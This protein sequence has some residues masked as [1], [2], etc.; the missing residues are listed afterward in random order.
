MRHE[1]SGTRATFRVSAFL[2]LLAVSVF[3][4]E[5]GEE[6]TVA[7]TAL[8]ADPTFGNGVVVWDPA[9]GKHVVRGSLKP[10][11]DG[12]EPA[13]GAAQWHSRFTLAG[14][15]AEA[16]PDGRV[17][18]ADEAKGVVFSQEDGIAI[19]LDAIAEYQGKAPE[20]GDP[21]PHLL[22]SQPRLLH[23]PSLPELAAVR[24]RIRYRLLEAEPLKGPGWHDQRHTA[25]V[26]FFVTVQNLNRQS[27][28]YGDFLWFGVPLYDFRYRSPKAMAAPDVGTKKKAGTGKFMYVPAFD[29][30]S[31]QSPHDG[32]WVEIETDLLPM[33]K[34]AVADAWTR[35]YLKDSRDIAD[36]RL[37]GMN[38]GWEITGP[39]RAAAHI[40]R[41]SLGARLR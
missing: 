37:G 5:K 15:E 16:L 4:Q 25:Q 18:F 27:E 9:P 13:W 1:Q 35:G 17:R 6:K 32:H 24:F 23:H 31:K 21:W 26:V 28:G 11:P 2:L 36:Y 10:W 33:L 19:S 38:M 22:L 40:E 34:E 41:I 8:L 3:S 20:R 39:I 7:D 29:R 12:A 30:F 14:A